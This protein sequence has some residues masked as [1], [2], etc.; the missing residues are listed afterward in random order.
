MLETLITPK[1]EEVVLL[2]NDGSPIGCA[3]K[4]RI[5]TKDTPL[6]SAFS[7]F[8]FN[9][10]GQMLVQQRAW[11]KKTWPGIWSNACCGHPLPGESLEAAAHRRLAD[12]LGLGEIELT[13]ALPHF[14]YRAE[15]L[16]V[17]ENEICPVF[18]GCCQTSPRPNPAEVAATDWVDWEAFI[19]NDPEF[20]EY[21]PWSKWEAAQLQRLLPRNQPL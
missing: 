3:D 17:V 4:A 2:G 9:R 19:R 8:L 20:D 5:H 1:C 14:R 16:G 11:S 21:S 13:L 12:E 15:Y 10:E 18:V 7:V 6:H